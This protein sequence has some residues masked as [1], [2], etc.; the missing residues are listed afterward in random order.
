[1]IEP[2]FFSQSRLF[3]V[4]QGPSDPASRKALLLCP[5]LFDEYRRSYRVLSDLANA[6]AHSDWHVMRFDYR[7][8]GDSALSL[9]EV[10]DV[11]EWIEDIDAALDELSA[12]SGATELVLVSMRAGALFSSRVSQRRHIPLVAW[13]PMTSGQDIL[14]NLS[15]AASQHKRSY[16]QNKRYVGH[17]C[18]EAH[19]EGFE[20][21][22]ELQDSFKAL[23]WSASPE[24]C[25]LVK[26]AGYANAPACSASTT[27]DAAYTWPVYEDGLLQ[28]RQAMESLIRL[29][30]DA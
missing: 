30:E 21:S 14:A 6:Y 16:L 2:F 27:L 20:L 17:A 25:K 26:S 24:L 18:S 9:R 19:F 1:M 11:A 3:G 12:I 13:D 22:D 5:P 28:P 29:L 7:G 15:A 23:S 4:Y 10:Q 8:T